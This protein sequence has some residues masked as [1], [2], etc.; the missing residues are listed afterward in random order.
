MSARTK[1]RKLALDI[2]FAAELREER[3]SDVLAQRG[4]PNQDE[5][6]EF[7]HA[8]RIVEGVQEHAERIDELIATYATGWT[9]ERMPVVDRN[10]LRMGAFE[11]L[12]V[13]DVP[14]GVAVTEAVK[15]ATELSTD[16][17]PRFVNG[18]LAQLQRLKPSLSL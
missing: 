14:D 8:V 3:P 15:L 4:R 7:P 6:A 5:L 1:A 11:L 16:E 9:L 13:D 17:S 12:W 2:L 18:L 10:I